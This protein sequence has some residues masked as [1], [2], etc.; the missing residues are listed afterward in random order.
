MK[1]IYLLAVIVMLSLA[2]KAQPI[3]PYSFSKFK[4]AYSNL[5]GST[6]IMPGTAWD[7]TTLVIP[8]GFNFK[9]AL[10]NSTSD[11][12]VV[13]TYGIFSF[14]DDYD[15]TFFMPTRGMFP[16]YADMVDFTVNGGSMSSPVSYSTTGAVGSRI[17][18]V[19]FQ[20]VGFFD[21]ATGVDFANFQLWLYETSNRIEFRYGPS[22]ITDPQTDFLGDDGTRIGLVY[23]ATLDTATPDY[24]VD[25][26]S[27]VQG[28]ST[29]A[30]DVYSTTS[31]SYFDINALAFTG[32]PD[33]GQ[34]F[35]YAPAGI[36]SGVDEINKAFAAVSV[37][38]T[39]FS[40]AIIMTHDNQ[41]LS[42]ELRDLNGRTLVSETNAASLHKLNV[43]QL[44]AGIY[45]LTLTNKNHQQ[46]TYKLSH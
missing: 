42:A 36:S 15:F 29:T 46:K 5:S 10:N 17:C 4:E 43:G 22:L 31:T 28:N 26:C 11:S 38:P 33:S 1:K 14:K 32:V 27:Y 40:D 9:W 34:V 12:L 13:D 19:E 41:L 44:P 23:K 18:K 20:H 3:Y 6:N 30:A 45:M 21:D 8:I 35:Q 37:F 7:D 24:L 16:F 2:V 39:H 25:S